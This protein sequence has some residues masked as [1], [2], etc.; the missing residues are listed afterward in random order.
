MKKLKIARVSDRSCTIKCERG[1]IWITFRNSRDIILK[2]G[3]SVDLTN[4]K[5][6]II[7][8]FEDSEYIVDSAKSFSL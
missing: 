3:E 1:Y 2:T 6:I 5:G 4:E 7:Q 8:S